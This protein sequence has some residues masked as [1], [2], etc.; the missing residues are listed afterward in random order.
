MSKKQGAETMFSLLQVAERLNKAPTS[1]RIW[2]GQ[3]RFP[4]AERIE[5]E[6][7]V[8]YWLIPESAIKQFE[9]RPVGRPRKPLSEL[10][11]KPRRK[12]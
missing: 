10:K 4:G 11:G 3:G 6:I 1:I 2:L 9:E 8:P 12:S 7:G 5:P